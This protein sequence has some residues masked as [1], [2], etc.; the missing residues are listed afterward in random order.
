MSSDLLVII[1]EADY[2]QEDCIK[3]TQIVAPM[4]E[5]GD[6]TPQYDYSSVS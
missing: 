1:S 3:Q 2:D 4:Q 5:P 6:L